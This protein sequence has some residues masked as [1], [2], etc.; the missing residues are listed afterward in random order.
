MF[1]QQ[2]LLLENR[3][4]TRGSCTVTMFMEPHGG[5]L[6]TKARFRQNLP[7]VNQVA[8]KL[9]MKPV[10]RI[11]SRLGFSPCHSYNTG[12]CMLDFKPM[13]FNQL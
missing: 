7:Y 8:Q 3:D 2:I 4:S 10:K 12:C 9:Q 13:L 5:G 11:N 6:Q 1:G